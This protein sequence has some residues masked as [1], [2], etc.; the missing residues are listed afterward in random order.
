[1]K[2]K[3]ILIV[4][5]LTLFI[6]M[7]TR[8][9]QPSTTELSSILKEIIEGSSANEEIQIKFDVLDYSLKDGHIEN[10]GLSLEFQDPY[11]QLKGYVHAR[12]SALGSSHPAFLN[13]GKDAILT[14]RIEF[15][16][17]DNPG[18]KIGLL[19]PLSRG[20]MTKGSWQA[21]CKA[22]EKSKIRDRLSKAGISVETH[23]AQ[24]NNQGLIEKFVI[25]MK[26]LRD[27]D[28]SHL[29][30]T[31]SLKNDGADITVLQLQKNSE[32]KSPIF[33]DYEQTI[34]HFFDTLAHRDPS[35]IALV[36]SLVH[37]FKS[38]VFLQHSIIQV[39]QDDVNSNVISNASNAKSK[40]IIARKLP[41]GE[42]NEILVYLAVKGIKVWKTQSPEKQLLFDINTQEN[43]SD[44]ALK[45]LRKANLPKI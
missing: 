27:K 20:P 38:Y 45:L 29:E 2:K 34:I 44:E 13:A 19:S 23:V 32:K 31:V 26:N 33:K 41:E 28:A 42:A 30:L 43:Q 6:F 14:G 15:I 22:Y 36:Q 39:L 7:E 8:A 21:F 37:F 25:I 3:L 11:F 10:L 24:Y 5:A 35:T 16:F 12:H 1:M 4:I 40:N 18:A 9:E 17:S